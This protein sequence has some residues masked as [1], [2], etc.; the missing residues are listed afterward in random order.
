[1]TLGSIILVAG[2]I[3]GAY[4]VYKYM[5]T[6]DEADLAQVLG[7]EGDETVI[8]LNNERQD[9]TG[10]AYEGQVYLPLTWINTYINEKFYWD[11]I[12][13]ML[14][15]TLPDTIVY[16]DRRTMGSSGKPLL[17][18]EDDDVYLS[19]GLVASYTDIETD[20]FADTE[21][22]R[23][24]IDNT[25]DPYTQG[26]VSRQT[27]VRQRGGVKSPVITTLDAGE[28]VV[29]LE[30]L[31]D[32]SRVRSSD[33]YIGYMQNRRIKDIQTVQDESTFIEP[34]YTSMSADEK[35]CLAWHQ[36][37]SAEGN[38]TFDS[39]IANTKGVNVIAP[40]WF[41]LTDNDGNYECYASR[42]YVDKAHDMGLM[43]W[44]VL[45]N[46]NQGSDVDSE[47]LFSRT[48]VRKKLISALME[49]IKTYG[50][51]GINL[52]IEGIKPAAGPHYV[53]FI[54]EL[55]VSCRNE[56]VYLSIDNYVPSASSE[57][58]N[59]AEQG[60]V[61]DYVIIMAYDEH[62]A[63][64]E[65]GSVSS[66]AY[67]KDGIE[68]TLSIVPKEK[69]ICALPFYTRIWTEENG[70]TTSSALGMTDAAEWV[71]R[72][73]VSLYWQDALGQYYGSVERSGGAVLEV[74]MEDERSIGLKMDV[75][76]ENDLAG[77]AFWKLGF[78]P[79]SIWDIVN[80]DE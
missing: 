64:G 31:E 18:V 11:D 80:P 47:V 2:C 6:K 68:A 60:R 17:L 56:G 75:I 40:T 33:G 52:D 49:D 32:W 74:W 5:P 67:V 7:V 69:V 16:A 12:E 19:V 20:I 1:M 39:L 43:V 36:V 44:G 38:S 34:E 21:Y 50:L 58:Y 30:E 55:S 65:A 35:I 29:I 37:M 46:F 24:F 54:R 3:A 13:K 76:R 70:T 23:A 15:Y 8:Y 28:R 14:V 66:L 42:D 22:K 41:A 79:S 78:E 61:A 4:L 57:F 59:R 73:N 9:E 26:T 48:S 10:I 25:W 77:S 45:D 71:E 53:E 27:Q 63:G 51:D 62:Y 72:N